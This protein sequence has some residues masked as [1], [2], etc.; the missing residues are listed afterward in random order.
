MLVAVLVV[1]IILAIGISIL[2]ITLKE[3]LLSGVARESA[4][5]LNA[6]DAGMECVLYWDRAA[7]PNGNKFDV[8]GELTAPSAGTSFECM[9]QPRTTP[10]AGSTAAQNFQFSWGN[11]AV[12]ARV[13]MTK[14]FS[15][16]GSVPMGQNAAGN[17]ISCP[18]GVECTRVVSLGYD[19][20]C[21]AAFND[22][23][24]DPRTV[25]RGFRALY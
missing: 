17:L 13:T 10:G 4:I 22:P 25:E 18:Q 11:P 24:S 8:V 15:T 14:Y 3:Y 23:F 16:S 6:A 12:C 19:R 7:P 21:P 5:A 1:S 2:S 9:G 20:A